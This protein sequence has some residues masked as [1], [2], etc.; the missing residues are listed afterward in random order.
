MNEASQERVFRKRMMIGGYDAPTAI[1]VSYIRC[2]SGD[3]AVRAWM[4]KIVAD[5]GG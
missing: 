1:P 2:I 3:V 5:I 4:Y